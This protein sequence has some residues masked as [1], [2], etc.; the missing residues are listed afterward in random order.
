MLFD[1]LEQFPSNKAN[2]SKKS[3]FIMGS[4]YRLAELQTYLSTQHNINTLLLDKTLRYED[5]IFICIDESTKQIKL[6]GVISQE[7]FAIR[8]LIYSHFAMI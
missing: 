7:Y 6:E 2:F 5:K 8:K 4:D 1:E 3:L